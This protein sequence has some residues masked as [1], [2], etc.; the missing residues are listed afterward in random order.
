MPGAA[1]GHGSSV[2]LYA[3]SP[4][5]RGRQL[6]A[7]VG[8]LAWLVVW[9][10]VARTVHAAVLALAGPARAAEDLGSSVAD[11]MGSAADAARG[12]GVGRR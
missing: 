1:S 5:L 7:D 8:L 9:V 12:V 3:R 11:S 4:A 10:L 2:R 6:L